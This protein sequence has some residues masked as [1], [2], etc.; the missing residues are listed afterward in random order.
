MF[1]FF[2]VLPLRASNQ[3]PAAMKKIVILGDEAFLHKE[4]SK[5]IAAAILK[6]NFISS[7]EENCNSW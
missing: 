4:V 5:Q 1:L 3:T 6:N 2:Q 7:Y